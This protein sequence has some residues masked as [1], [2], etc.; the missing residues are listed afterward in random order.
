MS[1]IDQT[2][3]R[4]ARRVPT[5]FKPSQYALVDLNQSDVRGT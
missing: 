5:R 2:Y 3:S 1:A 4:A